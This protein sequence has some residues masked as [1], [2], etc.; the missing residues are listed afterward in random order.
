MPL[1]KIHHITNYKYDRPVKE[2]VNQVKIFPVENEK[3]QVKEFELTVT[4]D[5]VVHQFED[6]FGNK[7]GDFN[8][9]LRRSSNYGEACPITPYFM[10]ACAC[11]DCPG[12]SRTRLRRRWLRR[13]GSS[14]ARD[15][16]MTVC[17]R[18]PRHADDP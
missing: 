17:R 18:R 11:P 12:R 7:V 8:V 14:P 2:N 13:P 4:G 6:F 3:Q 10:A 1:F 15:R 16:S 5:P 9:H